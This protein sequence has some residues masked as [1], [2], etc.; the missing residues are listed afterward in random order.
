MKCCMLS[1][2]GLLGVRVLGVGI[3]LALGPPLG[4]TGVVGGV[5]GFGD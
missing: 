4:L 5:V 3:L 2:D 1:Y